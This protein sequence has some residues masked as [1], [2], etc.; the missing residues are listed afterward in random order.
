[1]LTTLDQMRMEKPRNKGE[2][3]P[4]GK[5]IFYLTNSNILLAHCTHKT[6]M[7]MK[8]FLVIQ[9][10]ALLHHAGLFIFKIIHV[11]YNFWNF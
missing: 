5:R 7:G 9:I 10:I 11:I 6:I 1:M 2:K 3:K 8:C 4:Y